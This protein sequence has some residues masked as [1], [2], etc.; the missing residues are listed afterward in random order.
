MSAIARRSALLQSLGIRRERI[1]FLLLFVGALMLAC[2]NLGQSPRTWQDEGGTLSIARTLV[3]DNVYAIRSSDG[4]QTFGSVQSVGPTVIL[5]IALSFKLFGVGLLQGRLVMAGWLVFTIL[6]FYG[7]G[8]EIFGVRTAIVAVLL[9]LGFPLG[10]LEHG[11]QALG[12][13]P[14]LGL[15]LSGCL[16]W[17]W[18]ERNTDY[19]YYVLTGVLFGL[20]MVTKSQ[21]VPMIFGMLGICFLLNLFYYKRDIRPIIIIGSL[22]LTFFSAWLI[23]QIWYFGQITFQENLIKLRALA[24]VTMGLNAHNTITVLK[25]MLGPVSDHFYYFFGFPALIYTGIYCGRRNQKNAV[26]LYLLVFTII[27]II[28]NFVWVPSAPIYALAPMAVSAL[29]VAK[30]WNDFVFAGNT[31]LSLLRAELKNEKLGIISIKFLFILAM[32]GMLCFSFG[33]QVQAALFDTDTRPKQI[34]EFLNKSVEQTA[35]I[36]TWERELGV[37]TNHIYH[38]P[39]Q[40]LLQRTQAT[41]Y[42]NAPHEY[43][44][45]EAY[46]QQIH[47]QYLIIGWYARFTDV[48]DMNYLR[49]HACSLSIIGVDEWRYE[50]YRIDLQHK[51]ANSSD[52]IPACARG[53]S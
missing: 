30:L 27:C 9:M 12:E 38:Y 44:L 42:R 50:V 8:R 32:A 52:Q 48:Y 53:G 51:T 19:K 33:S 31:S 36:E 5:P 23:W 16:A 2:Y 20:S 26:L 15:F 18:A 6:T 17:A 46:F 29:L 24:S 10:I 49:Q 35:V 40:S 34:T 37:L 47:P 28:Y 39:D 13:I 14:A 7:L 43:L 22:A 11:R 45:G 3:E 25:Y 21:Y 4:Y 1:I 41:T